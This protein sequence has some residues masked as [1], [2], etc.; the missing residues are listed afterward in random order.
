[1]TIAEADSLWLYPLDVCY[2]TV[3]R[4]KLTAQLERHVS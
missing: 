3:Q 4:M 2:A 1:M